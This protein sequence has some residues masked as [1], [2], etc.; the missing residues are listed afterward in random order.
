MYFFWEI[1]FLFLMGNGVNFRVDN[2]HRGVVD[3]VII[4]YLPELWCCFCLFMLFFKKVV[5]VSLFDIM[6]VYIFIE[7]QE[8][9]PGLL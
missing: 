1:Y 3:F 6:P 8:S 4:F 9:H 5:L 2:V 7:S